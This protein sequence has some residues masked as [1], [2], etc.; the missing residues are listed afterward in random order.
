MSKDEDILQDGGIC[1]GPV[2]VHYQFPGRPT[3]YYLLTTGSGYPSAEFRFPLSP[4]GPNRRLVVP[5]AAKSSANPP[6]D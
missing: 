5:E 6:P 4:V 3:K 2:E 1:D